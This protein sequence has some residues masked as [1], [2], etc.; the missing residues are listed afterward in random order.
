M[1][2]HERH[3]LVIGAIAMY[4]SEHIHSWWVFVLCT[5]LLGVVGASI[6]D[7]LDRKEP[8]AK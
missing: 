1:S 7:Y 6:S 8:F 4:I 5:I 2:W 3:A